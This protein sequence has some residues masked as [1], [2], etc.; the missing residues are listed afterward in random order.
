MLMTAFT[1]WHGLSWRMKASAHG[2]G[3]LTFSK[4]ICKSQTHPDGLLCPIDRR[5]VD[6]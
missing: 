5:Y 3:S 4:K 2:N 1:L 6:F